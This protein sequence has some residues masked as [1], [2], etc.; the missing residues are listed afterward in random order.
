VAHDARGSMLDQPSF[1]RQG[2]PITLEQ[3]L[4]NTSMRRIFHHH[5]E[6][7]FCAENI[8]FYVAVHRYKYYRAFILFRFRSS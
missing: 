6:K 1:L 8:E 3:V 4:R 5:V 7:T 2:S